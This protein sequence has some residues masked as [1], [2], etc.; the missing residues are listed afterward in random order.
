MPRGV[1]LSRGHEPAMAAGC[2]TIDDGHSVQYCPAVSS[3]PSRDVG[4]CT[5]EPDADGHTVPYPRP[6]VSLT[7]NAS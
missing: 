5:Q 2:N 7:A 3:G 1:S 4:L 6:A